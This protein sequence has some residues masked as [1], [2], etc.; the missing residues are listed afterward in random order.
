[1]AGNRRVDGPLGVRLRRWWRPPRST[2]ERPSDRRVTFLELFYDLVYVVVVAEIGHHLATH[3]TTA[4]LLE[5]GFMFALVWI[6]WFNGSLYHEIHGA[7]D[8]R[9]RVFTFAQMGTVASMAVFVH[10]AFGDGAVGFAASFAA[11]QLILT[12]L[13]WQ[14]GVFDPAHRPYSRPYSGV[15]LVS[16]LSFAVSAWAP[17]EWVLPLWGLGLS[18]SAGAPLTLFL[19]RSDDPEVVAEL[20][21][22]LTPTPSLV[23]RFG[24]FTIIVLG[25]VIVAVV[26]G[27]AGHTTIDGIVL[28]TAGLG[29]LLAVAYWWIYFDFVSGRLPRATPAALLGWAGLHLPTTVGIV[30]TGAAV[31]NVVE[32]AR[33]P[34]PTGVRWLLAGAVALTLVSTAG[35][36]A[37]LPPP[38][39]R[40]G[41]YRTA[42][43][44]TLIAAAGALALGLT[45]LSVVPLLAALNGLLFVLAAWGVRLRYLADALEMA[46]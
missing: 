8:L 17:P 11:Y 24:L 20:E 18:L 28:A 14:T 15:F 31:L 19:V 44:L 36:K 1:M 39:R 3:A 2:R 30:A 25:E 29:M 4:G 16:A 34:L 41:L 26:Q 46:P 43:P 23:E 33:Q 13:W 32:H 21:R 22:S 5:S 7:D 10:N 35:V 38:E 6:A 45:G 27:V 40:S 9:T 12:N 42:R 37:M